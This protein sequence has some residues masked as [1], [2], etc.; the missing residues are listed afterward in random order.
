MVNR[1][2]R[3]R[4]NLKAQE[5]K[6]NR[7]E[8][9]SVHP[10]VPASPYQA[11]VRTLFAKDCLTFVVFGANFSK[12]PQA[13]G[14]PH[15]PSDSTVLKHIVAVACLLLASVPALRSQVV[16]R[17][18]MVIHPTPDVQ[19][20]TASATVSSPTHSLRLEVRWDQPWYAR[21]D[22]Y[23]PCG[24]LIDTGTSHITYVLDPA[25][26]GTYDF[27]LLP[28]RPAG[29]TAHAV[30]EVYYDDHL[31]AK[32]S[33]VYGQ[34][35]TGWPDINYHTPHFDTFRFGVPHEPVFYETSIVPE[36]SG[37]NQCGSTTSWTPAIDSIS[38]SITS[39]SDYAQ[40]WRVDD[41]FFGPRTPQGTTIT[42]LASELTKYHLVADGTVPDSAGNAVV[43][44]ARSNGIVRTDTMRVV[45]Y[46]LNL[47]AEPDSVRNGERSHITINTFEPSGEEYFRIVY[48]V[49]TV[50]IKDS[51][52]YG[53]LSL[54]RQ[55]G[56]VL[57]QG[58]TLT[59]IDLLFLSG[60]DPIMTLNFLANE[61][62]PGSTFPLTIFAEKTGEGSSEYWIPASLYPFPPRDTIRGNCSIQM[63]GEEDSLAFFLITLQKDSLKNRD[64]TTITVTAVDKDT[65]EVSFDGASPIDLSLTGDIQYADFITSAGDTVGDFLV[66]I[67]YDTLRAGKVRIV[68]RG[69]RTPPPVIVAARTG[70]VRTTGATA[71]V[72]QTRGDLPKLT[73]KAIAHADATKTG[74]K[75]FY[76]RPDIRIYAEP[77]SI[78]PS[79][80]RPVLDDDSQTDVKVAV[81]F[82]GILYTGLPPY[83]VRLTSAPVDSSGGHSH[84]ANRPTGV[85]V[86]PQNDTVHTITLETGLD[87][88][89]S[90]YQ[91]SL[92]GGKERV[93]ATMTLSSAYADTDTVVVRVPDLVLLPD[94]TTYDKVGGTCR[95][96][97]PSDR[98][99]GVE[100]ETPDNNHFAARVVRDS[101]PLLASAWVDSLRQED[102]IINDI[103]LPSG[104]LFD[105]SGEWRPEHSEHREGLDVDVR[106]A[107]AGVRD[108]VKVRNA[109]GKWVGNQKFEKLCEQYGVKRAAGH[110]KG[111][112]AEHYHLDY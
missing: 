30:F 62:S 40:F 6:I 4:G 13:R 10:R 100:C 74:F 66:E 72:Q 60:Q 52:G 27:T 18:K 51:T 56:A 48:P 50:G 45:S 90:R 59:D 82:S 12:L 77:D 103:S 54:E 31:A 89:R 14:I 24:L 61:K 108:G 47:T 92:F 97:G 85:F 68:A 65:N 84:T 99:I 42:A 35:S 104:G 106:T 105:V 20:S 23:S 95:H 112:S 9:L 86:N 26:A 43:V 17:E 2:I 37:F 96:H 33:T 81:S 38:L 79:Y 83:A 69:T 57:A 3:E 53:T 111:T 19:V 88:I 91:A 34:F 102:L 109:Q 76:I 28:N 78:K 70:T 5:R 71:Q 101:L 29:E 11:P 64:V 107:I 8:L 73:V 55:D 15:P 75:D 16:I 44:E 94:G 67:P 98:G 7:S 22:I 80:L 63:V 1:E 93:I 46:L 41:E 39:G 32:D 110:K 58:D 25:P 36:L 49:V 87:T 21:F